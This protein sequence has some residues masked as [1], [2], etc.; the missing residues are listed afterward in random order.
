VCNFLARSSY[1]SRKGVGDSNRT[2]AW[3]G[4]GA[5]S[6]ARIRSRPDEEKKRLLASNVADR[7]EVA[8]CNSRVGDFAPAIQA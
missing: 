6:I 3:G 4:F 2:C 5:A 7:A 1:V 8:G